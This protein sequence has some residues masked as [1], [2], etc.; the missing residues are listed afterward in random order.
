MERVANY[1][2]HG[3]LP[4]SGESLGAVAGQSDVSPGL[5]ESGEALFALD[6]IG[7]SELHPGLDDTGEC[8]YGY[9][10]E[11]SV[12]T[13]NGGLSTPYRLV[14]GGGSSRSALLQ[15]PFSGLVTFNYY[16]VLKEEGESEDSVCSE[17]GMDHWW[18]ACGP[19]TGVSSTC[20]S[21]RR[22]RKRVHSYDPRRHT[23]L[24]NPYKSV[25]VSPVYDDWVYIDTVIAFFPH[26]AR[27]Q[28]TQAAWEAGR[29]QHLG[30]GC[31]IS[32]RQL[33]FTPSV[34]R[35][36]TNVMANSDDVVLAARFTVS[37]GISFPWRDCDTEHGCVLKV[38]RG[39]RDIRMH[40]HRV[41]ALMH[42]EPVMVRTPFA[43]LRAWT[44]ELG[45]ATGALMR[46]VGCYGDMLR[47]IGGV[48]YQYNTSVHDD[49][50][51]DSDS[52]CGVGDI[53]RADSSSDEPSP[54]VDG[55]SEGSGDLSES[56]L[57]SGDISGSGH[58]V[59][60][61]TFLSN[62][63]SGY[64]S[65]SGDSIPDLDSVSDSDTDDDD[66]H[67]DVPGSGVSV[68][69]LFSESALDS[70]HVPDSGSSVIDLDL[71]SDSSSDRM[72]G[73]RGSVPDLDSASDSDGGDD[74]HLATCCLEVACGVRD[75]ASMLHDAVRKSAIL[76]SGAIKHIFNSAAVFDEDYDSEAFE[77]FR[78]VQSETVSSAG[79]G[80][81]TFAKRDV[82]S[83]RLVG[84]RLRDA[85]CIPGQSFNLISVVAL[86]DAGFSVDFGARQVS[87]GG[88]VFSFSR[89]ANPYVMTED[90][91]GAPETYMACA[92]HT[93]HGPQQDKSDWKFEDTEPHFT[94]HGP[95]SL[96]LFA[97]DDNHILNDYCT[98][99]DTCF[100]KDL[101]SKSCYGNPPFDH[102]IILRCLQK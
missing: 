80:S 24:L 52:D 100:D 92:V 15:A 63:N 19:D 22:P 46:A 49:F 75:D 14:H 58:P 13:E 74:E 6:A 101:S 65:D 57:G 85:H 94:T 35:V 31:R 89:V 25:K 18:S 86:E 40:V 81:V 77:T 47:D 37:R 41:E 93:E 70:D 64:V 71:L 82:R 29:A 44:A 83:G 42:E 95:F 53:R 12:Q 55:Y 54:G 27:R 20:R 97:S 7:R 11:P 17:R 21:P 28:E 2:K 79:S 50:C 4:A 72:S 51:S 73:Y 69:D 30:R 90:C 32:P 36:H 3:K 8:L 33:W 98:V 78:V 91:I 38:A 39:L 9:P 43:D 45:F 61:S 102:Q 59:I 60:D 26:R 34:Q 88:A 56:A 87:R 5:A 62:S 99:T 96:E 16:S 1:E 67:G 48:Q 10:D 68:P 84:L 76:D 23:F 66:W